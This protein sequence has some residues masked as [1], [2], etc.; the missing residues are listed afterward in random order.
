MSTEFI[1]AALTV[2][3]TI[4]GTVLTLRSQARRDTLGH[5]VE[6]AKLQE[7]IRQALLAELH[8]ELDRERIKRR[9]LEQRV[10]VL[11]AENRLLEMEREKRI[12]LE[13]KSTALELRV[14]ALERENTELK[15]LLATGGSP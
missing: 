5:D 6:M 15:R 14:Q 4:L 1:I 13:R 2:A 7:D 8:D 11:E 3:G 9:E 12:E 10:D